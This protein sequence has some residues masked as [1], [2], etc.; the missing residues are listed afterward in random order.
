M[1]QSRTQSA[2]IQNTLLP[3]LYR[4]RKEELDRLYP[5]MLT[6]LSYSMVGMQEGMQCL[7]ELQREGM[8]MRMIVDEALT[9]RYSLPSLINETSLDDIILST[10]WKQNDTDYSYLF[11]PVLSASLVTKILNFDDCHPFSRFILEWLFQGKKVGALSIGSDPFQKAWGR[12]GYDGM[13]PLLKTEMKSRLQKLRGYGV[14]LLEAGQ[15]SGWVRKAGTKRRQA[16]LIAR[17]DVEEAHQQ[18]RSIIH[19]SVDTIIT[20]L[21][22]DLA[23]QY[24]IQIHRR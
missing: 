9:E 13:S 16:P 8:R 3:L 17:E 12:R 4:N 7:Q 18:H 6:L 11:I 22:D 14:E 21:A 15:V 2:L 5:R 20:P 24:G 23:R 19:I 10:D 1:K